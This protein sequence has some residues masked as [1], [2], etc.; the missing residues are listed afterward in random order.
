[1]LVQKACGVGHVDSLF[2]GLKRIVFDLCFIGSVG[3]D[4][5]LTDS[6]VAVSCSLH[7]ALVL[8]VQPAYTNKL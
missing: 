3:F 6:S 8:V 1:F 4:D 7:S 2:L 5:H